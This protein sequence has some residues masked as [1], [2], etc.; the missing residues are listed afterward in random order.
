MNE[1]VN[2]GTAMINFPIEEI[3]VRELFPGFSARILHTEHVTIAHV[4]IK[5]GSPLPEHSHVHEQTIQLMSGTF[6]FTIEG[7]TRIFDKPTIIVV[8][9]SH[10]HSGKAITDCKIIDV[11]NPVRED[12]KSTPFVIDYH[13]R[14]HQ[15]F[16]EIN[17]AWISKLFFL[18]EKDKVMLADP[19]K[20]ILNGGGKILL[21]VLNNEVVGTCCLQNFGEGNYKLI[22]MGVDEMHRGKKIGQLLGEK[23]LEKAKELKAKKVFLFSNRKGSAEAI[24]L[25][26]KLGFKE[27]PMG[28]GTEFARADIKME[29][30]L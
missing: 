6:E 26:F 18:E 24:R 2:P 29:I 19:E 30:E 9:S 23:T 21:A 10:V 8:P 27:V 4:Q 5:G 13:P 12:F 15:R 1:T 22:K 11:F 16:R 14:Y 17:E 20:H 3:P 28:E 7:E 25:Y